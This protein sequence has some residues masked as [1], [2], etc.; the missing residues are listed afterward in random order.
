MKS[1]DLVEEAKKHFAV[2]SEFGSSI[3]EI[4]EIA[5]GVVVALDALDST[6]LYYFSS[7]RF[8][9]RED[10]LSQLWRANDQGGPPEGC[11]ANVFGFVCGLNRPTNWGEVIEEVDHRIVGI[12][13]KDV[14]WFS[15]PREIAA[16]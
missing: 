7:E 12:D 10:R 3:K 15:E 1:T 14:A 16:L 4:R 2:L 5:C 8:K 13:D 9:L 11:S 6:F